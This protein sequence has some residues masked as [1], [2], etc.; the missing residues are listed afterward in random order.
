M[1]VQDFA[2]TGDELVQ[3]IEKVLYVQLLLRL[4]ES[5]LLSKIA[6]GTRLRGA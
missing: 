2:Y 3:P 4:M 1:L 6:H 5:F